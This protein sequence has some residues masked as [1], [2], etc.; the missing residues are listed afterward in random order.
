MG[1]MVALE[2]IIA[3]AVVAVGLEVRMG[4]T[5]FLASHIPAMVAPAVLEE[6]GEGLVVYYKVRFLLLVE[7]LIL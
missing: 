4:I 1:L 2:M 3:A 7:Q 6:E 5:R